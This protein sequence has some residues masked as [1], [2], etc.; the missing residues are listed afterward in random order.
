MVDIPTL[1]R[2][3]FGHPGPLREAGLRLP[4]LGINAE[5]FAPAELA[6]ISQL[7]VFFATAARKQVTAYGQ[8][9]LRPSGRETPPSDLCWTK[10]PGC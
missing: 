4:D 1:V 9:A 6:E 2:G 10:L 8:E 5:S 7:V 3:V